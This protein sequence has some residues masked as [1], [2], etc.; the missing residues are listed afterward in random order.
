MAY[1]AR[2][3]LL[4]SKNTLGIRDSMEFSY[5]GIGHLRTSAFRDSASAYMSGR[6]AVSA[7]SQESFVNDAL[8]NLVSSTLQY[9][10]LDGVG[11][12]PTANIQ[13]YA[14]FGDGTGRLRQRVDS[15][16][17]YDSLTYDAAGNQRFESWF[18]QGSRGADDRMS[19]YDGLGRLYAV[20]RRQSGF[21]ASLPLTVPQM[22]TFEE[23]RYDP[24]G[25]RVLVR[26]RR[27]CNDD[28]KTTYLVDCFVNVMRRTVWDGAQELWEIQVPGDES[29]SASVLDND[30]DTVAAQPSPGNGSGWDQ[31]P[32]WGRVGYT[33]GLAL[34]QPLSLVRV[35]YRMRELSSVSLKTWAPFVVVPQWNARGMAENGSFAD[36]AYEKCEV[37]AGV[38]R[39]VEVPWPHGW[40]SMG[41]RS[42]VPKAWH[43]TLI[44]GKRDQS[45]LLYRRN[46]MVDPNTGRFTQQDPIGLAG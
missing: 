38:T 19:Y 20:D 16:R 1:D 28:A 10:G 8:G 35:G 44:E 4:R 21:Y 42:Y 9:A 33:F 45:S 7:Q 6:V 34:D 39:C 25:R 29:A 24:L 37:D 27:W 3:K 30:I 22:M 26:S 41:R 31:N 14:Y 36:G 2:G 12:P 13:S 23:Y 32:M 5:S 46:R 17:L 43:G 11:V 40:F 18:A 15:S